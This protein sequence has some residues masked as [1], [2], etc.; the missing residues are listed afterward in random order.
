MNPSGAIGKNVVVRV[1]AS[2]ADALR[3]A[4]REAR[5]PGRIRSHVH[6][7]SRGSTFEVVI[8]GVRVGSRSKRAFMGAIAN[9]KIRVLLGQM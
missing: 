8:E 1:P 6:F 9:H 5:L 2:Q 3:A 7:V 4:V